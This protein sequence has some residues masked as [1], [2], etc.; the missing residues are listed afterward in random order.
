MSKYFE[1]P[2]TVQIDNDDE[3]LENC[4]ILTKYANEF[5]IDKMDGDVLGPPKDQQYRN[6]G[7]Y[8]WDGKEQKVIPFGSDLDEYGC[9]PPSFDITR[10]GIHHFDN[11]MEHNS[12]V[13]IPKDCIDQI[14]RTAEYGIPPMLDKKTVWAYFFSEGRRYYVIGIPVDASHKESEIIEVA[15]SNPTTYEQDSNEYAANFM[16]LFIDNIHKGL[17]DSVAHEEGYKSKDSVLYVHC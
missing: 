4:E 16:R 11:V 1:I 10:F 9:L 14:M 15:H 2:E 13:R 17:I 3:S 8:F 7:C 12:Y 5:L 6:A